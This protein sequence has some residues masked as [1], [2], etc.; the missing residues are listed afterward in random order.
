MTNVSDTS[1]EAMT[2]ET[3]NSLYDIGTAGTTT[4]SKTLKTTPPRHNYHN[5]NTPIASIKRPR[6]SLIGRIHGGNND[7]SAT[8][9]D[10]PATPMSVMPLDDSDS[11]LYTPSGD[12]SSS[13]VGSIG[14]SQIL[15]SPMPSGRR[16]LPSLPTDSA[17]SPMHG[18][19]PVTS[20][21]IKDIPSISLALDDNETESTTSSW[22]GKKVDALFSPVYHFLH[23]EEQEQK[24]REQ[25]HEEEKRQGIQVNELIMRRSMD[26]H[27][28][29][30]NEDSDGDTRMDTS[31]TPEKNVDGIDNDLDTQP[32]SSVSSSSAEGTEVLYTK[33]SD[34]IPITSGYDVEDDDASSCGSKV[35]EGLDAS[36]HHG[37]SNA[38]GQTNRHRVNLNN[39]C[40][41]NSDSE[42]DDHS[43]GRPEHPTDMDEFNPW[44]FIKSLPPYSRIA[45]TVPPI[46]LPPKDANAPEKT[47]VLDLDET[48]VHCTVE[49]PDTPADLTFPVVFRGTTFT[50]H[51][52]LRP[53]LQTFLDRLVG[54]YEII[55]FTASQKVYANELLNLIDP[56]KFSKSFSRR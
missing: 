42:D 41:E 11:V 54:K 31:S 35:K 5:T 17:L 56:S 9:N 26:S 20:R 27:P 47:L 32:T 7:P 48:L 45:H 28:E 1:T 50:V 19:R 4:T 25:K 40:G 8:S 22:V 38:D 39:I 16:T 18:V 10:A 34:T 13:L 51:V 23:H 29:A 37:T 30:L 36:Y 2:R 46:T 15:S 12:S 44:H 21:D 53:F 24:T 49:T 33:D 3:E 14:A 52:R 43:M 6:S 55:V